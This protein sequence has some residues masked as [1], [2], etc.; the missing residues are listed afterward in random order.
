MRISKA[1][2]ILVLK[3]CDFQKQ[4][5]SFLGS[6]QLL[7]VDHSTLTMHNRISVEKYVAAG[8][9]WDAYQGQIDL[10]AS[11]KWK[12]SK[13]SATRVGVLSQIALQFGWYV[14]GGVQH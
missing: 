9:A 6:V 13:E 5:A 2:L 4:F 12:M 1:E 3:Q 11:R 8:K 10:M 14:D 7:Y